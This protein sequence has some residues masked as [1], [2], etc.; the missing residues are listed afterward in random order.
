MKP[1]VLVTRRVYPQAIAVL[2]EHCAV[3]YRDT[4]EVM[5][6]E[7]LG[8]RLRHA[9]GVVCQLTD[10]LS[11]E[12]IGAAPGLRVI[13]QIAVGHDNVDVA[14]ATARGIVVTNTPDVLTESTADLTMA[15]LLA[16]ARRLPQAERFLRAGR[17]QR[18]AVDLLAGTDVHGRTL[19]IVGLG[20]IGRA[21]ARRAR[22][23]G[24]RLLYAAPRP[25]PEEVAGELQAR[26]VPL[27]QLLAR[28]DFVTLHV[29]LTAA[30]RHL[31]GVDELARMPR[32]ALLI[33]TSR[34]PVVDEAALCAALEEGVIAGAGLDVFEREPEVTAGLLRLDNVVL[35]PHV[36]SATVATRT[37][38]CTLA[39]EN[40][41]AVLTGGRPPTP[42]NPQVLP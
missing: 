10:P 41:V 8:R 27:D 24:M 29:P 30:T 15:L 13:A 5:D 39:A 18:W 22:G 28:S 40:C 14:A 33:N 32:H 19:G 6:A 34:G 37:R 9:A 25:A 31:I 21:V 16:T 2:Q 17:W 38:M 42:V 11:A 4:P 1:R 20:R 3:D 36:G 26:H 35:L 7:T 12:V 23:F